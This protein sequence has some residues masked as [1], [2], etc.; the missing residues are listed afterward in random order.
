MAMGNRSI[1]GEIE[2]KKMEKIIR[3]GG[4][5]YADVDSIEI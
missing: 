4:N 2:Q 3:N 5:V 1:E